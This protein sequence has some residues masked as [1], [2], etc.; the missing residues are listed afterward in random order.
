[1]NYL[2]IIYC[3]KTGEKREDLIFIY[4]SIKLNEN[5]TAQELR[6]INGSLIYVIYVHQMMGG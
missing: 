5:K 4:N 6:L 3:I 1:M 2:K